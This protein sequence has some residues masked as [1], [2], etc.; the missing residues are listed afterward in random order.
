M[1]ITFVIINF[2]AETFLDGCIK[3]IIQD[4]TI[5]YE[6]IVVDDGSQK[7]CLDILKPY[8]NVRF[9][10]HQKNLGA[11]QARLTGLMHARGEYV[12]FVDVDDFFEKTDF[13]SLYRSINTENADI[14][15]VNIVRGNHDLTKCDFNSSDNDYIS[16]LSQGLI[17]VGVIDKLFRTD[18]LKSFLFSPLFRARRISIAEDLCVTACACAVAK[19]IIK[20]K[21]QTTYHYRMNPL[22]ITNNTNIGVKAIL[23]RIQ[24]YKTVREIILKFYLQH[25][26]DKKRVDEIDKYFVFHINWFYQRF[27]APYDFRKDGIK[28]IFDALLGAFNAQDTAK[29][30]L[31]RNLQRYCECL[32]SHKI[33][34]NCIQYDHSLASQVI[35]EANMIVAG[36]GKA[37]LTNQ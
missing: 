5:E 19:K 4:Q 15:I 28:R 2:N 7:S 34:K 21:C 27:I 13:N 33:A 30:L 14:A 17:R 16:I 1:Q 10:Q 3:S 35:N 9:F 26:I 25:G 11:F 29:F 31:C 12:Y 23:E 37:I 8:P 22:S 36:G 20:A 18:F 6:I 24:N 32:K